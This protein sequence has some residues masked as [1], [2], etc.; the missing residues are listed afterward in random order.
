M[1]LD[2]GKKENLLPVNNIEIGSAA[3]SALAKLSVKDDVKMKLLKDCV[4]VLL[5]LIEKIKERCPLNY[6]VV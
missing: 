5:K 4:T 1:K 6:A 3:T 2:L